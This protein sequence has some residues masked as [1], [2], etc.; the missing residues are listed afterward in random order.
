MGHAG[1]DTIVN[2]YEYPVLDAKMKARFHGWAAARIAFRG[3][4]SGR[5]ASACRPA[6]LRRLSWTS[7]SMKAPDSLA[8]LPARPCSPTVQQILMAARGQGLQGAPRLQSDAVRTSL[9][10]A[11][12]VDLW[13]WLE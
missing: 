7:L 12:D 3:S 4:E 10:W 5:P 2:H 11:E 9:Q 1:Q 6:N 13:G 8:K